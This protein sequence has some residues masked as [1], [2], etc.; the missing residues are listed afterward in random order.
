VPVPR[1][2]RSFIVAAAALTLLLW[3][4]QGAAAAPKPVTHRLAIEGT[5]F[6]PELLTVKVGDTIVWTNK[7]PFPHTI[8]SEAGG[9]DSHAIAPG[10]SFT[11]KAA[12]KGDF[13]YTCTFHPTMKGRLRVE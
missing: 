12:K 5:T 3:S 4:G 2:W 7:D 8:T 9:F 10:E 1:S 13:P 6:T 11:Y